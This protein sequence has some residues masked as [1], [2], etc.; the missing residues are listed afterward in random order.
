V[1]VGQQCRKGSQEDLTAAALHSL[2]RLAV[3]PAEH[4]QNLWST[5]SASLME[6]LDFT[7]R[8]I[9]SHAFRSSCVHAFAFVPELF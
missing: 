9:D 5:C 2:Q 3:L 1:R 7:L 6:Q 4:F 8:P